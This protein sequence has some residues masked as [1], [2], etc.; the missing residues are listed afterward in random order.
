M[1]VDPTGSISVGHNLFTTGHT[2]ALNDGTFDVKEINASAGTNL[3]IYNASGVVQAGVA[4]NVYTTRK[5]VK[6]ASD[7]SATYTTDSY[8]EMAGTASSEYNYADTIAPFRV[9]EVNRGGGANYNVVVELATAT[10]QANPAGFVQCGNEIGVFNCASYFCRCYKAYCK[11]K[12]VGANDAIKRNRNSGQHCNHAL[13]HKCN[14][15][16]A[17][18]LDSLTH[19]EGTLIYEYSCAKKGIKRF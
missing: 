2:S 9:V 8:I 14:G 6:F 17:G 15:R 3:I 5:L 7:Q 10:A 16:R 18:K 4:G 12:L 13:R 1:L 19:V 11:P